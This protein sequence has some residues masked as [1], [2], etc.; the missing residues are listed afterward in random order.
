MNMG[1]K[2]LFINLLVILQ[3]FENFWN[4]YSIS[5]GQLYRKQTKEAAKNFIELFKIVADKD[6]K[7]RNSKELH[8]NGNN[9]TEYIDDLNQAIAEWIECDKKFPI[10]ST[11]LGIGDNEKSRFHFQ[12]Y[13]MCLS[14][15]LLTKI[16]LDYYP[17][18][19]KSSGEGAFH[20]NNVKW[21]DRFSWQICDQVDKSLLCSLSESETVVVIG[22]IRR[23]QD[24]IT[25]SV[26]PDTYRTNMASLIEK[27]KNTVLENMGIFDRFTGDG[28]ICYFNAYLLERFNK[29][30]YE[31]VVDVCTKIQKESK[32]LFDEWQRGLQKLSQEPIGLSIGVDSGTMNFSD[33]E[34]MF[35]IGTPAVWATRMC[36]VGNAGD[37]ILNNIPHS[38]ICCS[39]LSFIFEEVFGTTKTGE[40]F[41][42]FKLRHE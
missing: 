14:A 10:E 2:T 8:I 28:F 17:I 16:K 21:K 3:N 36:A 13:L 15:Y 40:K 42:A 38:K 41:K 30:L 26:N 9:S 20:Y 32:P 35:A 4:M 39:N 5:E 24:L 22:D 33:K 34:L 18:I 1:D 27:V 37:I 19:C 31:T 11:E 23:S 12:G 6:S 25:Y 29:D 7:I